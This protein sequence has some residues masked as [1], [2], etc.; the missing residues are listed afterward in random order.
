MIYT[1]LYI[2]KPYRLEKTLKWKCFKSLQFLGNQFCG[3]FHNHSLAVNFGDLI[4]YWLLCEREMTIYPGPDNNR[5]LLPFYGRAS[6]INCQYTRR[7]YLSVFLQP[8]IISRSIIVVCEEVIVLSCNYNQSIHPY[9]ACRSIIYVR[10]KRGR[11]TPKN[12]DSVSDE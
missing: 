1:C 5:G 11:R 4:Y 7:H 12:S 2:I 9:H 10:I 6:V 8:N 3:S